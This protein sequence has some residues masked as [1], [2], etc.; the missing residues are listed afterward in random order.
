MHQLHMPNS[1]PRPTPPNL[2][3]IKDC[4]ELKTT[5]FQFTTL[6]HRSRHFKLWGQINTNKSIAFNS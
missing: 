4:I 6:Q 2:T 5:W 1:C 3:L